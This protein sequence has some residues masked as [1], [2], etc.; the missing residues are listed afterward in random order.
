MN[1]DDGSMSSHPRLDRA[2]DVAILAGALATIPLTILLEERQVSPAVV[3]LDWLVWAVFLFEFLVRI[4][5]ASNRLEHCRRNLLPLA[6]VVLSFPLLPAILG[7]ARVARLT[8][9]FRGLRLASVTL[10]GLADLRTIFTRR[11]VLYAGALACFLILA[12]G[13]ALALLEPETAKGGFLDGVWWAVVTASTVGYGDIAPTTIWGRLIAV[14]MILAG[15]GV[16]STLSASITA[17]F[18]GQT[19]SAHLKEL[20]ERTARIEALLQKVVMQSAAERGGDQAPAVSSSSGADYP[21]PETPASVRS[22]A[23]P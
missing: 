19:E 8:R 14:L 2:L 15:V 3:A 12:G 5:L 16:I 22:E 21:D 9:I 1:A 18:L 23:Q 20:E 17:Y 4:S 6:V 10:R 7:L 13:G 11:G